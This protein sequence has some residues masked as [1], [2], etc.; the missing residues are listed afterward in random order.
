LL[1]N[2]VVLPSEGHAS[3]F[4]ISFLPNYAGLP[5]HVYAVFAN[6][7]SK[8]VFEVSEK[9]VFEPDRGYVL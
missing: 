7:I 8:K 6:D 5:A 2:N 1:H 3:V 4:F 9:R